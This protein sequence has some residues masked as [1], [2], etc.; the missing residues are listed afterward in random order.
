MDV[1][2]E[3]RKLTKW[4]D[5]DVF[6]L[7][8]KNSEHKELNGRYLLLIKDTIPGW[9]L[10]RTEVVLRA[11]ITDTKTLPKNE[12]E[13]ERLEYIITTNE[14]IE[15]VLN[16]TEKV[17]ITKEGAAEYQGKKYYFDQYGYVNSY[18]IRVW[19]RKKLPEELIYLGNYN[20]SKPEKEYIPATESSGVIFTMVEHI[21][22]ILTDDYEDLNKKSTIYTHQKELNMLK[23]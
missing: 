4:K 8:I 10:K 16:L 19:V 23:K 1:I 13:I 15:G 22:Q 6:A 3:K 7:P 5:G 21:I 20:L 9:N 14:I 11:K 17:E 12:E 18:V 2:E